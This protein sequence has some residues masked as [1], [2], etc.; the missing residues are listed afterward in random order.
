MNITNQSLAVRYICGALCAFV[1]SVGVHALPCEDNGR[2]TC[3]KD[4]RPS[5]VIREQNNS[6]CYGCQAPN[7]EAP[8][9]PSGNDDGIFRANP[10]DRDTCGAIATL[11][12]TLRVATGGAD[13]ARALTADSDAVIARYEGAISD[14]EAKVRAAAA[15]LPEGAAATA[16]TV[17]KCTA[18][19]RALDQ[20]ADYE[21]G[22]LMRAQHH[23]ESARTTLARLKSERDDYQKT[24]N[25][26]KE[27]IKNELTIRA[28][29][30]R[31]ENSDEGKACRK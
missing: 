9:L 6:P 29:L 3:V 14:Q 2:Q 15:K 22:P 4:K 11:T 1:W 7:P 30:N 13:E 23:F 19:L 24:V 8:R 16:A 25:Q 10:L 12:E 18:K 27:R 28:K 21:V 20:C 5:T 26:V 17:V 31:L